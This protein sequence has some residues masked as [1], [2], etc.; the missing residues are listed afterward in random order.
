MRPIFY[1]SKTKSENEQTW[2][3]VEQLVWTLVYATKKLRSYLIYK[4]FVVLTSCTLLP[5][6]LRYL[7][8]SPQ[9]Q[10]WVLALQQFDMSFMKEDSVRVN[11]ADMI[12]YKEIYAK[13]ELKKN[14]ERKIVPSPT[15]HQ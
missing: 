10:K 13:K 8:D 4:P 9:L 11:I 2:H 1:V 12:T 5:Q 15:L 3:E 6:A 7:G 14:W